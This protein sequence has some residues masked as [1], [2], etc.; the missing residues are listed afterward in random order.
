MGDAQ[1]S[2][3]QAL[4]QLDERAGRQRIVVLFDLAAAHAA[5]DPAH[6]MTLAGQALDL[7]EHEPYG[8]AYGR[9]P[10]VRQ[11][12]DGTPQAQMLD[13]RVRAL[14]AAISWAA[15][16]GRVVIED[17]RPR[18]PADQCGAETCL[19]SRADVV[20]EPVTD[21]EHRAGSASRLLDDTGEELSRG[22]LDPHPSEVPMTS[23]GK[24]SDFRISSA[25]AV[26]LP[27]KPTRRPICRNSARHGRASG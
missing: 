9:I 2:L 21:V 18:P 14:P 15:G 3:Q 8:A 11:A 24:S 1:A 12:L 26:W 19:L 22:L 27:A 25:R 6:G 20:V 4:E 5:A 10:E 23:T 17:E 13:E 16:A 7:L